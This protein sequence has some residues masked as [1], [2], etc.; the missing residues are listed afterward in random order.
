MHSIQEYTCIYICL[1]ESVHFILS[2]KATKFEDK[3]EILGGGGG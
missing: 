2:Y 3:K 1:L